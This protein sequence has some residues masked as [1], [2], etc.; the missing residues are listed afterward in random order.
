MNMKKNN[1]NLIT[2][3]ILRT[4]EKPN[5]LSI[6]VKKQNPLISKYLAISL[7][8]LSLLLAP[9]IINFII[10][11][12]TPFSI[13]VVGEA[14][15]WIGFYGNFFSSIITAF[16]SFFILYKTINANKRENDKNRKKQEIENLI[17]HL[18]EVSSFLNFEQIGFKEQFIFENDTCSTEINTLRKL[19]NDISRKKFEI[20]FLF[21]NHDSENSNPY[22]KKFEKCIAEANEKIESLIESYQNIIGNDL[23]A[24]KENNIESI[25]TT[26]RQLKNLNSN[27]G[28]ELFDIGKQWIIS[29]N[30]KYEKLFLG[31]Q[32][33][34]IYLKNDIW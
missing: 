4:V 9:I 12:S 3:G 27:L 25:K 33:L 6:T 31:S 1:I 13:L 28:K 29:E 17:K 19:K 10:G 11:L 23:K 30:E 22:L 15:D 24:I 16:I 34:R 20:D 2:N 32:S 7:L 26:Y 21:A 18:S 14:K 5:E 8:F